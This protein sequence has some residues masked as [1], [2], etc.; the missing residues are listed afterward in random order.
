MSADALAL[1][2]ETEVSAVPPE[3]STDGPSPQPGQDRDNTS[4]RPPVGGDEGGIAPDSLRVDVRVGEELFGALYAGI[5]SYGPTTFGN[6]N[7]IVNNYGQPALRPIVGQ[8]PHVAELC[9][10]YARSDADDRL[11]DLLAQRS[12]VC[13]T[14]PKNSGRFSTACMAL[15][16]KYGPEQVYEISLPTGVLP[17]ALVEEADEVLEARGYVLRLPGDGH[18]DA[19]RKL[20]DLFR[21][22]SASLLLIK[23]EGLRELNRHGAEVRHR[24]P[25]PVQVFSK[26]VSW[27]LRRDGAL[28]EQEGAQAVDTYLESEEIRS[29]LKQVYGPREVV[30]IAQSISGRHPA[31]DAAIR[32]ILSESQPRRRVRAAQ[33]LLPPNVASTARR[34]RAGQHERAFRIAYAVFRLQPMHYVFESAAWLLE[35]ID[36]AALRPEWGS[37]VLEHP[38]QDLLGEELRADWSDGRDPGNSSFGTTRSAWIR[39]VGLRGAI[40][41]VA[42]HDFDSTRKSLLKWLDRMVREGDD[43]MSRAAAETAGLLAHHDFHTVHAELVDDWAKSPSPRVRQAAAWV[44]TIAD[45]VGHVSHLIRAKLRDWCYGGTNYQRD[46]A[47]LVYASGLQQ[48]VLEWSMSDLRRIAEDRM[49]LRYYSVAEG[50]N[51]LYEPDRA[52]RLIAALTDWIRS[53]GVRVHAARAFLTMASRSA[54]DSAYGQPELFVRL[55]AGDVS[56]ADLAAV[57]RIALIEPALSPSAWDV[58][59]RW[60]RHADEGSEL[61]EHAAELLRILADGASMRRRILFF[62]SRTPDFKEGLPEW[63]RKAMEEL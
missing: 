52:A 33:I 10:I 41:D 15:A 21:R 22:R 61:R 28:S 18:V 40:L 48:R 36:D 51:Q 42:W 58:L 43:V 54:V 11:D 38:V 13:L 35:E 56:T 50:V 47:A 26:H 31:D 27:R 29:E 25:D 44:E 4:D 55:A 45:F 9:D 20:A 59:G 63:V 49:Q 17:E 30:V 34:H 62:L 46:T 8:L 24:Q 12:T 60:L 32:A 3:L 14:G 37:M 7:K 6:H 2:R 57:W 23:D 16:R 1:E 39:D 5:T 19:M 53:P